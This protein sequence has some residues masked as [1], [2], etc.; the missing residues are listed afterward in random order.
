MAVFTDLIKAVLV[1]LIPGLIFCREIFSTVNVA[2]RVLDFGA[3]AVSFLTRF[4]GDVVDLGDGRDVPS[5]RFHLLLE[6]LVLHEALVD[7]L[8]AFLIG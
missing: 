7:R 2:A 4:G 3:R 5:L 8:I 6:E 1:G